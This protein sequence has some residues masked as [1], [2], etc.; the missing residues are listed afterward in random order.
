[1]KRKIFLGISLVGAILGFIGCGDDEGGDFKKG[2]QVYMSGDV[3]F[4]IIFPESQDT[5]FYKDTTSGFTT[6]I[7]DNKL[8]L[9][10]ITIEKDSVVVK[11]EK[12]GISLEVSFK[13][14]YLREEIDGVRELGCSGEATIELDSVKTA[15][16]FSPVTGH[17]KK[18][19]TIY[20]YSELL[21]G[22]TKPYLVMRSKGV[23]INE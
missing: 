21:P 16:K 14:T 2:R 23:R 9:Q 4:T 6:W 17:I 3:A 7:Q 5:I 15:L 8:H 13:D 20:L 10:N 11:E 1:M 12:H 19:H 22:E 18:G